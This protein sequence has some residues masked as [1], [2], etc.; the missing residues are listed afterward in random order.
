MSSSFLQK[1][2]RVMNNR[3]RIIWSESGIDAYKECVGSNLDRLRRSS[4]VITSEASFP[5]LLQATNALLD[6]CARSTNK[7][8]LLNLPRQAQSQKK[9]R[10]LVKTE[11]NMITAFKMLKKIPP[12]LP[13]HDLYKAKHRS[14]KKCHLRL[15][16]YYKLK[17]IYKRNLF[18]NNLNTLSYSKLKQLNRPGTDKVGHLFNGVKKYT[19]D[20]VPD[21]MFE[22]IKELKTEQ[23]STFLI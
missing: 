13:L 21:G 15:V 10:S 5:L 19:G 7:T 20:S 14:L 17:D 1:A 11:R 23:V 22:S 2:P 8:I 4:P 12:Y 16:R 6:D 18:F 3:A 9:P